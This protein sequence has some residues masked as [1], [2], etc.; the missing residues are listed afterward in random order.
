MD[1]RV[2]KILD[3]CHIETDGSLSLLLM[4]QSWVVVVVVVVGRG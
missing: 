3:D 1:R 2:T 4:L